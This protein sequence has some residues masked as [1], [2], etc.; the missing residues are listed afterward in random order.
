[1]PRLVLGP[2][3]RYVGETEATV[4]VETDEPC[5]VIVL[6]HAAKS[7]HVEGHNYALV[8]VE[9][10]EPGTTTPYEVLLNQERHW[11]EAH[12]KFPPSVIRTPKAD[13]RHRM[14]WGSCRVAAPH[15]PPYS[16]KKDDDPRGREI[17]AV[18]AYAL[19]MVE[20]DPSAWPHLMLWLGDQ[21]YADEVSPAT[22]DFILTRRDPRT[23]PHKQ[24]ADF[25]EY[26]HLYYESWSEPTIRWFLSA[27]SNAMIFDD[28][29][30]H[31]DWNTSV[32]W[33]EAM[34]KKHWWNERIVGG[35]MSYW[36]YQ[37]VGNLSPR[38][39]ETNDLYQ[40]VSGCH[41]PEED[42]GLALREFA[43][44]A[45]RQ[46]DGTRW[47]YCRDIAGTRMLVIDS[48]AGRVLEPGHRSM[49]DEAE[50]DWIVE[51]A[52]GDFDH[53]ILATSLPFLLPP[54][55]H[56]LEAFD[57]AIAE[58]A[59]GE[60]MWARLGEKLR[61]GLDLEH[62]AAFQDSFHRVV[63]LVRA[64]ATGE[65]GRPPG[66]IVFLSG[67]IHNAYLAEMGFAPGTGAKSPVWQGVCS[68]IRNPLDTHERVMMK[69]AAARPVELLT[70]ALAHA[71]G[72]RDPDV[73]WRLVTGQA[74]D[75]QVSTLEWEG[76]QARMK[77]E[78]AVP[79]DPRHPRLELSFARRLA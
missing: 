2:I 73:R 56:Y 61:Q 55:L 78:K 26:A 41:T 20:R 76:R 51:H 48:R 64:I 4:W 9:G 32:E 69:V 35:F 68:P 34:R 29:D 62:W 5:E 8:H 46:T 19:R 15:E 21:I 27:V 25:E 14:L 57:E 50:W 16:L 13:T 37:H 47:S 10:L 71:A 63:R 3:L 23:P 45:D 75:N 44:R 7:F 18:Y 74:F 79:G 43:F 66:S 40:R 39:L 49:V 67:D 60:G 33:V 11:P 70:R 31:D 42:A 59:W 6:G 54:A 65:R 30:V 77:L 24:V 36:L 22:R 72:M 1:V 12:G 52:T 58:G 53:L 38:E 28:H 17:D